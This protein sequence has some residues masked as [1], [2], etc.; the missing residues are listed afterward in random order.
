MIAWKEFFKVFWGYQ[1]AAFFVVR[2][3]YKLSC[4]KRPI[5]TFFGGKNMP[6]ESDIAHQAFG[7]SHA[8][9]EKGY[10]IIT[11]GGAGLME[12]A[13]CGAQQASRDHHQGI[14]LT[15]GIG[16]D[17]LDE[18]FKSSCN[19][20]FIRA[21]YFYVRK[22]VLMNYSDAFI[23]FPG[24]YGTVD[25]LFEL[26]NLMKVGK[27]K[28]RPVFLVGTA[29]WAPLL[30]WIKESTKQGYIPQRCDDMLFVT[31][32]SE[33]ILEHITGEIDESCP[34]G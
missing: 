23:I 20:P 29:F 13:N 8:L 16:V 30:A 9:V 1:R 6:N 12:A 34:L 11:G 32:L 21:P 3:V 5:V 33:E 10:A 14:C 28:M 4:F 25:E 22:W 31:D 24:G 19:S 17:D 15:L 18:Q 26:L 7:L 2:G 27:L